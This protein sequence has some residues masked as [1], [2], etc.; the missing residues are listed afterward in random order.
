MN[1]L[2]IIMMWFFAFCILHSPSP[3]RGTVNRLLIIMGWFFAF[4][5]LHFAFSLA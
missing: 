3:E 2:L 5:I 1:R 4:C